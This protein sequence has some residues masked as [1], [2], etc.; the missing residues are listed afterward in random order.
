MLPT[1]TDAPVLSAPVPGA[2]ARDAAV[3]AAED[4]RR[5]LARLVAVNA[6]LLGSFADYASTVATLERH[7]G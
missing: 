1:L 2:V 4:A 6:E 7:A 3:A 5:E